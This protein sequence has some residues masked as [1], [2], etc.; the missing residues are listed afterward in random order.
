MTH[1]YVLRRSREQKWG[2]DV[3]FSSPKESLQ[4]T[5]MQRYKSSGS[6]PFQ[7]RESGSGKWGLGKKAMVWFPE[8]L[9]EEKV[10]KGISGWVWHR[11]FGERQ[12][13][14]VPGFKGSTPPEMACKVS[15]TQDKVPSN[16][17]QERRLT[18]MLF[19]GLLKI[20]C[21]YGTPSLKQVLSR[22]IY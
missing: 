17:K 9:L 8:M 4:Q 14:G 12:G 7:C 3:F 1:N 11:W 20:S 19:G 5:D 21:S 6:N 2:G 13:C 18:L 15:I 22:A 16:E 10:T